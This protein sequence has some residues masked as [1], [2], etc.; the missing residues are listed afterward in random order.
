MT[1][2]SKP[3]ITPKHHV[4]AC[5]HDMFEEYRAIQTKG[6]VVTFRTVFKCEKCRREISSG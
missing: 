2:A 6:S 5:G 4:C 3:H 1:D